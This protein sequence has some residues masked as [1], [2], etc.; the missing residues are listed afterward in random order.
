M[1]SELSAIAEGLD[2]SPLA[3]LEPESLPG[4]LLIAH[5]TNGDE[6]RSREAVKRLTELAELHQVLSDGGHPSAPE[7]DDLPERPSGSWLDQANALAAWAEVRLGPDPDGDDRFTELA[8]A[9]KIRLGADVMVE[10]L[11][12]AASEGASIT[13]AEFPFILINADRTRPRALF[14]LAHELGHLLHR[15]GPKLNVDVD[16]RG[17][18]DHERIANAFAAAYLM[19]ENRIEEILNG[20]GRTAASLAQMLRQFEVSYESLIYRLP[21]LRIINAQ[22]RDNLRA[23]GWAGLLSALDD[24]EMSRDLLAAR[25]SRLERRPPACLAARCLSG[26][27]DGTISAAPLAELLEIPVDEMIEVI[28][29]ID[30]AAEA[31]NSDYSSPA[32]PDDD[33]LLRFDADPLVA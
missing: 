27:L 1:A 7:F 11:G 21:N 18:D 32:D 5:R 12:E 20:H 17:R 31:I 19:P 8:Q 3:I 30:G 14:T 23:A 28:N 4:R 6:G 9:I 24:Q 15:D 16:L 22:G 10:S 26:V 25:G 2:V 29:S 33:A 13:D